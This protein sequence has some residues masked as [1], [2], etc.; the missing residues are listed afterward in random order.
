M[1][2]KLNLMGLGTQGQLASAICGGVGS[3]TAAGSAS[4]ANATLLGHETNAV[5]TAGGADSVVMPT[6]AQRSE[7]GDSCLV[8]NLSSTSLNIYPGGSETANGSTSAVALAQ[9]KGF[10]AKRIS[11]TNWMY[12]VTA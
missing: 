7:I 1:P 4:Q 5:T 11:S 12:V 9:N 3:I 6:T 10:W 2:R 8:Y